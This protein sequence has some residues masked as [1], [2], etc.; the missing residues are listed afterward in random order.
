MTN[1]VEHEWQGKPV[2]RGLKDIYMKEIPD[3]N[4][5][6]DEAVVDAVMQGTGKWAYMCLDHYRQHGAG[7]GISVGQRLHLQ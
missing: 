2:S 5:C 3:C 6:E 4:L 7:L 1:A